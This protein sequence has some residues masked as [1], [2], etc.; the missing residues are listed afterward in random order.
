MACTK[1][2][3]LQPG[4]GTYEALGQAVIVHSAEK[5]LRHALLAMRLPC[6]PTHAPEW[7]GHNTSEHRVSCSHELTRAGNQSHPARTIWLYKHH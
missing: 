4:R 5:F 3:C 7:P 2:C 6:R 1:A